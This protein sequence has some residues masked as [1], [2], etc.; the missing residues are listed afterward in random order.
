MQS[1]PQTRRASE[2]AEST[3]SHT[4]HRE[5][6]SVSLLLHQ[7][8]RA[9]ASRAHVVGHGGV[10]LRLVHSEGELLP[11]SEV[12]GGGSSGDVLG[13]V[14]DDQGV[15][16]GQERDGAGRLVLAGVP[17]DGLELLPGLVGGDGVEGVVGGAC[18]QDVDGAGGGG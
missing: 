7:A 10:G 17:D 12:A 16:L 3:N 13:G 9:A 4:S 14:V 1:L 2:P 8:H 15:S 6:E 18:G 5:Q 11:G